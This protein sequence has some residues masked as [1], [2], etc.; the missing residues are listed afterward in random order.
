MDLALNREGGASR[1]V[2]TACLGIRISV[3]D[4]VGPSTWANSRSAVDLR[5]ARP[6]D[7]TPGSDFHE[8]GIEQNQVLGIWFVED[9]GQAMEP[10]VESALD[11]EMGG[12]NGVGSDRAGLSASS[13]D[14][15]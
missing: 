9:V 2:R 12:P 7:H 11:D 1:T 5:H 15:A 6:S 14:A 8:R 3:S 4:S 10:G 13:I